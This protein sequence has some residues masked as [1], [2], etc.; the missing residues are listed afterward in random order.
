[1]QI[2]SLAASDHMIGIHVLLTGGMR[3]G[4][5]R[6]AAAE[7]AGRMAGANLPPPHRARPPCRDRFAGPKASHPPGG[8]CPHTGNA[9]PVGL[10]IGRGGGSAGP[11]QG[12]RGGMR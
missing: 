10:S 2:S 4:L 9:E 3:P 7:C 8:V 1:M 12:A 11:V 5:G 6:E